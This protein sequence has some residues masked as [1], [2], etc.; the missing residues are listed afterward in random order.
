[1]PNG[2][3]PPIFMNTERFDQKVSGLRDFETP[4]LVKV[5]SPDGSIRFEQPTFPKVSFAYRNYK[6][7]K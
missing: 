3:K 4:G 5:I 2:D 6:R 7:S 1:M